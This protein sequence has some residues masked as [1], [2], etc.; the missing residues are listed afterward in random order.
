MG[1]V[2]PDPVSEER[3]K[4]GTDDREQRQRERVARLSG[5]SLW[6]VLGL[7][8]LLIAFVFF[9]ARQTGF[10]GIVGQTTYETD[11]S[12]GQT[13]QVSTVVPVNPMNPS[14]ATDGVSVPGSAPAGTY[15]GG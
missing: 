5:T 14:G 9:A 11:V 7:A 12:G 2:R 13:N 6:I 15:G 1:V 8:A 10:G 4:R 3:V